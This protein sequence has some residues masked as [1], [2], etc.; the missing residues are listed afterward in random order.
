MKKPAELR[1]ALAAA[2]GFIRKHPDKLSVFVDEGTVVASGGA[3]YSHEYR[4]TLTL[5]VQDYA[6]STDE[7]VL[8]ILIWLRRAQPEL[9]ENP[10]RRERMLALEVEM[11]DNNRVDLEIKLPLTERVIVTAAQDGR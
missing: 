1:A 6:G 7:I 2:N 4:Y 8:P 10:A 5:I 9:F 11:L 3:S